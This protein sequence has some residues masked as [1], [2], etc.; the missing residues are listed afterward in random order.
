MESDLKPK[1]VA[2]LI[3]PG[4]QALDIAGPM[5]AF[6]AA[7]IGTRPQFQV[8]GYELITIGLTRSS[9]ASECGLILK[10]QFTIHAIPPFDTVVIPGGAGMR[11]PKIGD[12]VGR[13]LL[14]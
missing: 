3:Y 13:W 1:R 4:I 9:V 7:R 14:E 8:P 12:A 5:D 10:P 2:F 11:E 6:A